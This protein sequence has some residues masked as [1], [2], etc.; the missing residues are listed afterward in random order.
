ML[1]FYLEL[2]RQNDVKEVIVRNGR[3]EKGLLDYLL[4]KKNL[5]V[6]LK[7]RLIKGAAMRKKIGIGISDFKRLREEGFF[8]VDKSLFIKDVME[9]GATIILLPRPRRFGKT[10]N[11]SMLRYFFERHE[12]DEERQRAL[13]LFSGLSIRKLPLFEEHF[14]RYPVIF[15]TLKDVKGKN[16]DEAF[17]SIRMALS[18][19][20]KRHIAKIKED[21]WGA[22][23]DAGIIQK[24]VQDGI[25]EGP[26]RECLYALSGLLHENYGTP[27]VILIDE[28]DTPIHAAWQYGY[29][30]EMVSFMRGLLSGGLKDNPHCF[31]AVLTGILRVAKESIFS[32]LN[33]LDV[34]TILDPRFSDKFGL[35]RE[36]VKAA[37]DEYGLSHRM[38]EVDK[39]YN[40][41]KF[42]EHIIF[43]PWSILNF[44]DKNPQYP[45]PYWAN[46]SSN[47]L[48]KELIIDGGLEVR[49]K[50]ERLIAGKDIISVIDKNI[51]F[52]GLREDEEAIFNLFFFSGYLKCVEILPDERRLR[53]RLSVPNQEM[54]YIFETIIARWL[55]SAFQN[56][57]LTTMLRSL[58]N[59][60]IETFERLLNEFVITTLSFF[61][62]KGKNPEAVYQAFVL[63]M[64]LNLGQEYEISS[65]RELGYGRYDILV[66]PKSDHSR[67]AVLLEMKSIAGFYKEDPHKAMQDA[68]EQ[69]GK[70][71]YARELE[72]RGFKDVIKIAV[73]SDGKR[74]WVREV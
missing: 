38:E 41:Y 53:C 25:E 29:Y 5:L 74:V 21:V 31:K 22:Y 1:F 9:T 6:L 36:E 12:S 60:D 52:Q 51:V 13:S 4:S 14:G 61:D 19:E 17:W 68:V 58:V 46:T 2:D 39:W 50:V 65:N 37:L 40:G 23:P 66:I 49:E 64:L 44:I 8:L 67:Q 28:Y 55:R 33:N 10:L 35:T 11:L 32:D 72:A 42:G 62:A 54:Q 56:R 18:R 3:G 15:L 48:I 20:V 24:I 47:A 45:E 69:I 71:S 59:G 63:G 34:F 16:I 26:Y 70:R 30:D 57:K 27:P 43:N 7:G 73:V